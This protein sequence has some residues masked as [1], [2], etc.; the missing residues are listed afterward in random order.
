[1]TSQPLPPASPLPGQVVRMFRDR[2]HTEPAFLVRAPGR[3]NLIGEH[4]DYNGGFVLPMAIERAVWIALRPRADELVTVWSLDFHEEQSFSAVAPRHD[5]SAGWVEYQKGVAWALGAEGVPL[6]GWEGVVGGDIPIGGGLSSSAA[7]E[8]AAARA[9]AAVANLDWDP[10]RMARLARQAENHWVGVS[11][12]IMDQLISAAGRRDHAL[13]IDCRTLAISPVPLPAGAAVVILDTATRRSLESSAYNERRARCEAAA[14]H[15]GLDSLRD[16]TREMLEA[17]GAELE[18]VTRRRARHV[19]TENARTLEAAEALRA[20]DA[21]RLG[22][23]MDASHAS[24]RG[25]FEV[26]SPE[27]DQ[28]VALARA[29]PECLGARMTGAGFGGCAIAL[30]DAARSREFSAAVDAAYRRASGREPTIDLTRA[31]P[32]ADLVPLIPPSP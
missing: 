11:C 17:R 3:V 21:T 6:R 14:R 10:I 9:F 5:P 16:L 7:L 2:F 31:A 23:L 28:M 32:G 25:D 20:G 1:M 30:I 8:L 27:L 15:F 24:L 18:P 4:T 29:R 13:L 12:G 22:R 26:S 19:V